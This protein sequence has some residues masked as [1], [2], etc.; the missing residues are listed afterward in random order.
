MFV[1]VLTSLIPSK[2]EGEI[3]KLSLEEAGISN[4]VSV[5]AGAPQTVSIK[6]LPTP[7]KVLSNLNFTS[8]KNL[9]LRS[10]NAS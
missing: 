1:F 9:R 5:P 4:C 6:E 8:C 7:E 3:D 10:H 2:V